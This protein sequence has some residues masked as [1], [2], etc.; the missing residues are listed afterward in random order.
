[1]QHF[2]PC[3]ADFFFKMA[4]LYLRKSRLWSPL[5]HEGTKGAFYNK[6][7]QH[8]FGPWTAADKDKQVFFV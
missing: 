5:Y 4:L 8:Y 3:D 2:Q 1:M 7:T 6:E